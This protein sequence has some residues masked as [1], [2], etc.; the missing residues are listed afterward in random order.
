M[1]IKFIAKDETNLPALQ[2]TFLKESQNFGIGE[3]GNFEF[4]PLKA[5]IYY[6]HLQ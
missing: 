3:T 1:L 6:L 2:Q 4:R 5:G